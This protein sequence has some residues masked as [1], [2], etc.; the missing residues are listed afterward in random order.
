MAYPKKRP[1]LEIG[2]LVTFKELV[3]ARHVKSF[4]LVDLNFAG[5]KW[6]N[7]NTFRHIKSG[8]N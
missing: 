8:E 6:R 7:L 3:F 5:L 2:G 4:T 1:A